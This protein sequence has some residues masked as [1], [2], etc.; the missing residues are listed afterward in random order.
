MPDVAPICAAVAFFPLFPE[1]CTLL[2][3]SKPSGYFVAFG[4]N[5]NDGV[6]RFD[7]VKKL[8]EPCPVFNGDFSIKLINFSE[9]VNS[10]VFS[11]FLEDE[12]STV[13]SNFLEDENSTVL[14]NF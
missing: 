8:D 3:P 11:N 9:A 7:A 12:N 5:V 14:M 2:K 13:F 10:T 4:L 1:T 6:K